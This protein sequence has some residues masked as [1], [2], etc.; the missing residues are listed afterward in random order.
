MKKYWFKAKKT[1]WGISAPISWEGWI[2]FVVLILCILLE[3]HLTDINTLNGIFMI[4]FEIIITVTI[5]FF[6]C[7]NRI[8]K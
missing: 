2:A 4:L 7:R 6:V 5:F 8:E 1:G 3:I